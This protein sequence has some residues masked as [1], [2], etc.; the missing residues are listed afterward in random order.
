MNGI[1]SKRGK[2]KNQLRSLTNDIATNT[3]TAPG[4]EL[5]A[6]TKADNYS[7]TS[8]RPEIHI[9]LNTLNPSAETGRVIVEAI[10]EHYAVNGSGRNL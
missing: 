9:H 5:G 10:S 6:L 8:A 3:F 7:K 4:F 1:E 2:L